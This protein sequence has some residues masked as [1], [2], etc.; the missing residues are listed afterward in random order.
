MDHFKRMLLGLVVALAWGGGAIATEEIGTVARVQNEAFAS[1][2]AGDRVLQG[3][4]AIFFGERVL[5]GAGARL[6]I[7]FVDGTSLT[8]GENAAMEI[9]AF[10][11]DGSGGTMALDLLS[12]AFAFTTG[13]IGQ[14]DHDDVIVTTPVSTIGIRG[15][16]FWG[17]PIDDA[18]GVLI[19]DGAVEVVT[20]GGS[21]LLDEVGQGTS[22]AGPGAVPSAVKSWGEDKKARALATIA[23]D[24]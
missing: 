15:T 23:F 12:G 20:T 3:G 1:S 4:D 13:L 24:E 10:V 9:D 19:L 22:I 6:E 16:S 14:N 5:T 11:F 7:V 18:Y 21:V 2:A 17:G 8:L